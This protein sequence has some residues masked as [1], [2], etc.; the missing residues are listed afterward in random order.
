MPPSPTDLAFEPSFLT[1]STL[2]ALIEIATNVTDT[3]EGVTCQHLLSP[4]DAEEW[5]AVADRDFCSARNITN[6]MRS[7]KLKLCIP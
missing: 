3:Q 7:A 1:A 2:S 5:I 4:I 6:S